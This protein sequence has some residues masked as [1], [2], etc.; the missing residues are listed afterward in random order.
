MVPAKSLHAPPRSTNL[1]LITALLASC[2]GGAEDHAVSAD[3][4]PATSPVAVMP[5]PVA[6]APVTPD[7]PAPVASPA[8]PPA[9]QPPLAAPPATS[10]SPA[11]PPPS[12]APA[13]GA[14]P[15]QIPPQVVTYILPCWHTPFNPGIDAPAFGVTV[16]I[17]YTDLPWTWLRVIRATGNAFFTS[18]PFG[19]WA[20]ANP[21]ASEPY[22]LPSTNPQEN[23]SA[24]TTYDFDDRGLRTISW[25]NVSE[26][27]FPTVCVRY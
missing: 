15:A 11:A 25:G 6:P 3:P 26:S 13:P 17:N 19:E 24:N 22:Y 9:A 10:P 2:G 4:A 23:P 8:P 21:G 5:A 14:P 20:R 1:A 12:R 16:E 18:D 27:S 7:T